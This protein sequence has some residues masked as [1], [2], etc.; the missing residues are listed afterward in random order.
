M[1][2][3]C[4]HYLLFIL[5]QEYLSWIGTV[6]KQLILDVKLDVICLI[7]T[8]PAPPRI[9]HLYTFFIALALPVQLGGS[10]P[11]DISSMLFQSTMER[12]LYV[13]LL[14]SSFFSVCLSFAK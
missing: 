9:H 2:D 8:H 1:L 13:A 11:I 5:K 14:A 4:L 7:F 3:A 6:L 10:N 12:I